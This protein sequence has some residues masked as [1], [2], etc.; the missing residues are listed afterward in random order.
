MGVSSALYRAEGGG[1]DP[2][3]P[4]SINHGLS[5]DYYRPTKRMSTFIEADEGEVVFGLNSGLLNKCKDAGDVRSHGLEARG[6]RCQN[7]RACLMNSQRRFIGQ[8][9]IAMLQLCC[10]AVLG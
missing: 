2:R 5:Q 4:S 8:H 7:S 3:G 10:N 1:F 6:N 9:S